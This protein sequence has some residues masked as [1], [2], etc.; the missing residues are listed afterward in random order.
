MRSLFLHR[1]FP[2]HTRVLMSWISQ[3]STANE[4]SSATFTVV[5]KH[6]PTAFP[7]PRQLRSTTPAP[8]LPSQVSTSCECTCCHL[9]D[10]A[11]AHRFEGKPVQPVAKTGKLR[12]LL[13]RPH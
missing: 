5:F 3:A 10:K 7:T 1:R 12:K 13:R 11:S 4:H 6:R 8:C 9:R 2:V